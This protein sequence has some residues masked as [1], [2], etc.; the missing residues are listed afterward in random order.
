MKKRYFTRGMSI[1]TAI[2]I[3]GSS[4]VNPTLFA[5]AHEGNASPSNPVTGNV[6]PDTEG[7][8]FPDDDN[9]PNTDQKDQVIA[10]MEPQEEKLY[11]SEEAYRQNV[12]SVVGNGKTEGIETKLKLLTD[13]TGHGT[14]YQS[15]INSKNGFD[16]GDNTNKDKIVTSGDT[17]VY[18][19]EMKI[20]KGKKRHLDVLWSGVKNADGKEQGTDNLCSANIPGV[21]AYGSSE[22]Y[23]RFVIEEGVDGYLSRQIA[24]PAPQSE[25]GKTIY[26]WKPLVATSAGQMD[27]EP[28]TVVSAP[29]VDVRIKSDKNPAFD[30]RKNTLTVFTKTDS[31]KYKNYSRYKGYF[32]GE[33]QPFEVE[34]DV[35]KF[36]EGT[37]FPENTVKNGKITLTFNNTSQSIDIPYSLPVKND[38]I[39]SKQSWGVSFNVIDSIK[40]KDNVKNNT[41]GKETNLNN[42]SITIDSFYQSVPSLGSFSRKD[43][44]APPIPYGKTMYDPESKKSGP[45]GNL[46]KTRDISADTEIYSQVKIRSGS[47]N[48]Y[49]NMHVID[50][51]NKK[52]VKYDGKRNVEVDFPDYI[53]QELR[54]YTVWYTTKDAFTSGNEP[55]VPNF[56]DSSW[57]TTKP[58]N[59]EDITGIK[60]TFNKTD[61]WKDNSSLD[62]IHVNIPQIAL[63]EQSYGFTE[64]TEGKVNYI[65]DWYRVELSNGDQPVT[66]TPVDSASINVVSKVLPK[67]YID[68]SKE[69]EK[70][71][72]GDTHTYTINPK[73]YDMNVSNQEL[74]P[75]IKEYLDKCLEDINIPENTMKNYNYKIVGTPGANCGSDNPKE[76]PYIEFTLKN[77]QENRGIG[78]LSEEEESNIKKQ[79]LSAP[80]NDSSVWRLPTIQ[81]SALFSHNTRAYSE[82]GYTYQNRAELNLPQAPEKQQT[83]VA[84]TSVTILQKVDIAA[85]KKADKLRV[86]LDDS[87]S[88][89]LDMVNYSDKTGNVEFVDILPYNG[90]PAT[91]SDGEKT[92]FSG[93]I[94]LKEAKFEEKRTPK[95]GKILYTNHDPKNIDPKNPND[96]SVTWVENPQ[97]IGGID[98]ATAIKVSVP[99][100]GGTDARNIS[101]KLTVQTEGNED[102]DIFVN[103]LS[104]ATTTGDLKVPS[105]GASSVKSVASTING[106]IWWDNDHNYTNNDEKGIGGITVY[107]QRKGSNQIIKTKTDNN[108]N[109]TFDKLKAGSYS[110]WIDQGDKDNQVP[111]KGETRYKRTVDI[112]Q[113]YAYGD[114]DDLASHRV[115]LDV[116]QSGTVDNV[117]FGFYKP[118]STLHI[119][120]KV[121]SQTDNGD[122][123]VTVNYDVD[124]LNNGTGKFN[125]IQLTDSADKE[126]KLDAS[127]LKTD[128]KSI[129]KQFRVLNP[130]DTYATYVGIR[131][132]GKLFYHDVYSGS[133]YANEMQEVNLE[134]GVKAISIDR[135]LPLVYLSDGKVLCIY[136]ND[137]NNQYKILNKIVSE[138]KYVTKEYNGN[139]NSMSLLVDVNGN[140][141]RRSDI[142]SYSMHYANNIPI[143]PMPNSKDLGEALVRPYDF[144]MGDTMVISGNRNIGSYM[145]SNVIMGSG[146]LYSD[147]E[148]NIKVVD[149]GPFDDLGELRKI[150]NENNIKAD[151]IMFTSYYDRMII[152]ND[153]RVLAG[154][155]SHYGELY[156]PGGDTISGYSYNY[157]NSA[158]S[159]SGAHSSEYSPIAAILKGDKGL[160]AVHADSDPKQ[161]GYSS[162]SY[163]VVALPIDNSSEKEIGEIKHIIHDNGNK[164]VILIN[165]KGAVY[166]IN[167]TESLSED[168]KNKQKNLSLKLN[169]VAQDGTVDVKNS[170]WGKNLGSVLLSIRDGELYYYDFTDNNN[171]TKNKL[172]SNVKKDNFGNVLDKTGRPIDINSG[173]GFDTGSK[174]N[175][176]VEYL[177]RQMSQIVSDT[178]SYA[179]IAYQFQSEYGTPPTVQEVKNAYKKAL[180][181]T[182]EN[183]LPDT[184]QRDQIIS[185]TYDTIDNYFKSSGFSDDDQISDRKTFEKFDKLGSQIFDNII[186]EVGNK[187]KYNDVNM[188]KNEIFVSYLD[189]YTLKYKE[190]DFK[191]ALKFQDDILNIVVNISGNPNQDVDSFTPEQKKELKEKIDKYYKDNNPF[192][193]VVKAFNEPASPISE[194]SQDVT[195]R[196][197]LKP[198]SV[199]ENDG[200]IDRVYNIGSLEPG[201]VSTVNITATIPK[202]NKE[203]FLSNVAWARADETPENMNT[204]T[205]FKVPKNMKDF[206]ANDWGVDSKSENANITSYDDTDIYDGV[207]IYITKLDDKEKVAIGGIAWDDKNG[208]GKRD[209]ED[210]GI[211]PGV[212][213]T[214]STVG[215]NPEVIG[216]TTTDEDGSWSIKVPRGQN[217]KVEFD[218]SGIDNDKSYK[219]TVGEDS[220]G[221]T[222]TTDVITEANDSYG[223]GY[224]STDR[225]FDVSK[226]RTGDTPKIVP[227]KSFTD[228]FTITVKNTLKNDMKLGKLVDHPMIPDGMTVKS[229]TFATSGTED[230]PVDAPASDNGYLIGNSETVIKS[231]TTM[232]FDVTMVVDVDKDYKAPE[233]EKGNIGYGNKAESVDNGD[234]EKDKDNNGGEFELTPPDKQDNPNPSDKPGDKPGDGDN[235]PT[236]KPGDKPTDKPGDGNNKPTDKP[237]NNTP[238][239]NNNGG[240]TP[241][242]NNGGNTNG[243]NRTGN[244]SGVTSPKTSDNHN[245]QQND[246]NNTG[247]NQG[248]NNQGNG[249]GSLPVYTPLE[250]DNNGNVTAHQP[251]NQ[252]G[253]PNGYRQG[254]A[255]QGELPDNITSGNNS[256]GATVY[257]GG[258]TE[259]VSW[260]TRMLSIFR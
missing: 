164:S 171:I 242:G 111:L 146:A 68:R 183:F 87:I 81:Y 258:E 244:N 62:E 32:D 26:E 103:Q 134:D 255:A 259:K 166:T 233:K 20:E 77:N 158:N 22:G 84:D 60:V 192:E 96:S 15:F 186:N 140:P 124:V 80:H 121:V 72:I 153:G 30:G 205:G 160:Y 61:K 241:H 236:D 102:G 257:T 161:P 114:T 59:P 202:K 144:N 82:E 70:K 40:T 47:V 98:K 143:I 23:C 83:V 179:N 243:N 113:S 201:Q 91:N 85:V 43:I 170:F 152:L 105:P 222:L 229:V 203:Q 8:V 237:G 71:N 116:P 54:D 173:W 95:D 234:K 253:N 248:G 260:I 211:L 49:S 217:Y 225:E 136:T 66:S 249:N 169:K 112:K 155:G 226:T 64:N 76:R 227:G 132:D 24:L 159:P 57:T 52:D 67:P 176:T 21:K 235:K 224:A 177:L 218:V 73:I 195:Q 239:N 247:S 117:S 75:T 122:G 135:D 108:G 181:N 216:T 99:N 187:D 125:N 165:D 157:M 223:V 220:K 190:K 240:N 167:A 254:V 120:K 3:A 35:S 162:S 4:A 1:A 193:K 197:S 42:N 206:K 93:S 79:G 147:G 25:E 149:S 188:D 212:K 106:N 11:A 50:V 74:T 154:N 185:K 7:M 16:P 19:L 129:W 252:L 90:S 130:N 221:A 131:G 41:D 163:G 191:D 213:V 107:A 63:S 209:K 230:K 150:I 92:K 18:Q 86:G 184:Q 168:L 215:D 110:V 141:V 48:R 100:F 207:P 10:H 231:G 9:K 210:T 44:Y 97:D 34:V 151:D 45:Y 33:I 39:S 13:G 56:K 137:G 14:E 198:S 28:V 204:P 109:Y 246:G 219:A 156:I 78:K 196:E 27:V 178:L 55:N 182:I 94:K 5:T 115:S 12:D 250:R 138:N 133:S 69:S 139:E 175:Y 36:P 148:G 51:W 214:V 88:W 127:M 245:A 180:T 29:V 145:A 172:M 208:D 17:V 2:A 128:P 104:E 31:S 200:R 38:K 126:Q 256:K 238:G 232:S 251:G 119:D 6:N 53:P 101:V 174:N 89:H 228:T 118:D 199:K 46:A 58:S 37:Q 194:K 123:T 142:P 189:N 65:P